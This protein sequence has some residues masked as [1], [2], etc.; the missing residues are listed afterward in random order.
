MNFRIVAVITNLAQKDFETILQDFELGKVRGFWPASNGIENTNYYVNAEGPDGP[1]DY[2]LTLMEQT[3]SISPLLQPLVEC[4]ANAGLPVALMIRNSNGSFTGH[5]NDKPVLISTRLR[6]RHVF[7]PTMAQCAAIGRFLARFHL[8]SRMQIRNAEPHPR[9]AEWLLQQANMVQGY[10]PHSESTLI[11]DIAKTVFSMLN[12]GDVSNLPRGIIH[13]DLFRD[14]ALFNERGLSGVL[15]FH[16]AAEGYW[17]FDLAVAVNDWCSDISGILDSDK[18]MT[19]VSAYQQIRPLTRH[20]LWFFP[21]FSLYAALTF[22]LSRLTVA[23]RA[24][25][26]DCLPFKN[27]AE[28][29]QIA[30]Q[31]ASRFFYLDSR[32]FANG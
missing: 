5:Y 27:P 14:N 29:Q 22:W 15:D 4:C 21:V 26:A 24:E 23:L 19:L 28:F 7:N 3:S 32:Q 18:T 11:H 2:V 9:N 1:R 20:E 31:R 17:L 10:I 16:Q 30:T 6:G 8:A 25:D 12:R 13:G